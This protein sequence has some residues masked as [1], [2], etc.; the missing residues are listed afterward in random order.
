LNVA[1]RIVTGGVAVSWTAEARGSAII[2]YS[3]LIRKAD[4]QTYIQES[5]ACLGTTANIIFD[6]G[7]TI[8]I[9]T[10][11]D[12]TYNLPWGSSIYATIVANNDYGPSIPSEP[13]NGAIILTVPTMPTV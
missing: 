6:Q 4:G 9:A 7:C 1:T 8:P 10:L 11:Q 5:V 13:G 12:G 3:V 2:S